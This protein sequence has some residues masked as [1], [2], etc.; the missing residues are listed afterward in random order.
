MLFPNKWPTQWAEWEKGVFFD[1][2]ARLSFLPVV[3]TTFGWYDNIRQES[4]QM[5]ISAIFGQLR[6]LDAGECT[7]SIVSNALVI[8]FSST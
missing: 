8:A 6:M 4:D 7:N 1:A 5:A 3:I 2:Q